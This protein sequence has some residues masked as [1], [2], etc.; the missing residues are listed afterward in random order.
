VGAARPPGSLSDV[1]GAGTAPGPP[2]PSG[3]ARAARTGA[4]R[5]SQ[6]GARRAPRPR[7]LPGPA[8]P[9]RRRRPAAAAPPPPPVEPKLDVVNDA[10][11]KHARLTFEGKA[12]DG[13][14]YSL[15]VELYG[16]VDKDKCKVRAAAVAGGA[17]AAAVQ[18]QGRRHATRRAAAPAGG[19]RPRRA[20]LCATHQLQ[21]RAHAHSQPCPS[22]SALLQPRPQFNTLPRHIFLVL[23]KKEAGSW[24]RLTKASSKGD[25]HIK[26][27]KRVLLRR[28]PGWEVPL[29]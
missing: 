6:P 17:A 9:T 7:R 2:A 15:D 4:A 11:G 23:E 29:C 24:P 3:T 20:G 26:V 5:C 14:T 25:K 16:A 18:Q 10:D 8:P 1:G 13:N 27:G 22:P 21:R 12:A 19:G 28:R